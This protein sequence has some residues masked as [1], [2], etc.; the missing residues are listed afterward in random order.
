MSSSGRN[1]LNRGS[2][3]GLRAFYLLDSDEPDAVLEFARQH[4]ALHLGGT[5]EVL[6]LIEPGRHG[7]GRR[8]HGG[9]VE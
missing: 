9:S 1:R 7:Q 8:G 4:P 3:E 5:A 6:P 2:I